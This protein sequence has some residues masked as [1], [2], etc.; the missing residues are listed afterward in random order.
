MTT[1]FIWDSIP[2]LWRH[3]AIEY[4]FSLKKSSLYNEE[5]DAERTLCLR[6]EV[7]SKWKEIGI[8]FQNNCVFVD[9]AGFNTRMIRDRAWSKVGEP[10]NVTVHK[11]R[12]VNINSVGCIAYFGTVNVLKIDL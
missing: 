12:S 8:D 9:E 1:M 7:I 3:V 4:A 11:Q 10:T 6:H 5:R 2:S